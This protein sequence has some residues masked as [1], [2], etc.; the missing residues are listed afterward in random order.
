MIAALLA[1]GYAFGVL[2]QAN[3]LF[4]RAPQSMLRSRI[5]DKH[6]G[7]GRIATYHLILAPWGPIG[8][9][10][11]ATVPHDVYDHAEI[12]DPACIRLHDGALGMPWFTAATCR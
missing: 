4:D 3:V 12:D 7:H 6:P 8:E 1:G 10:R 9:A 11:D 2:G 5:I